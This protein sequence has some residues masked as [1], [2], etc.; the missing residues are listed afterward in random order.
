MTPSPSSAD[1]TGNVDPALATVVAQARAD[2]AGRLGVPEEAITVVSAEL[3]TWPDAGLG[4]RQ[5][6]RSY[7]QVVSDGS[8]TV[9]EHAGGQFAYHTG[10]RTALPFY[11]EK[12]G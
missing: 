6:G 2:L 8:R 12:P 5:P 10:G 7:A 11:C 1:P 4:C 9:L 3:V